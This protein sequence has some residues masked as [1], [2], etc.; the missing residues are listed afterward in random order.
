MD[1]KQKFKGSAW[2][3][4]KFT[5]KELLSKQKTLSKKQE[6]EKEEFLEKYSSEEIQILRTRI[7]RTCLVLIA[8]F[9]MK[10]PDSAHFIASYVRELTLCVL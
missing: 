9:C 7:Q 1:L 3:K 8:Q 10:I 2:L 4:D 6:E 5:E